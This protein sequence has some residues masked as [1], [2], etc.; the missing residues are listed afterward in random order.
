MATQLTEVLVAIV[1]AF[2]YLVITLYSLWTMVL[3]LWGEIPSGHTHQKDAN[4]YIT[5]HR[6]SK[7]TAMK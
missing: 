4:I 3:N 5:I 6:S 1:V 2:Q 7:V